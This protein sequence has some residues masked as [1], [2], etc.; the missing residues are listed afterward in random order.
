EPDALA[1]DPDRAVRAAGADMTEREIRVALE[2]EDATR[3]RDLL[4]HRLGDDR[5]QRRSVGGY[6]GCRKPKT[7]TPSSPPVFATACHAPGGMGS[8]SP[9]AKPTDSSSRRSSP[10]PETT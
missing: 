3:S 5:H 2:R 4:A 1:L 8:G 7:M 9:A 6:A 10:V